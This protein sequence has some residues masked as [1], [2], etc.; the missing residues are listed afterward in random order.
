MRAAVGYRETD[1]GDVNKKIMVGNACGEN[2]S[3]HGSKAILLSHAVVAG[4]ITIASLS[5]HTSIGVNN[6]EAGP[7]NT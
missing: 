5:P 2:L 4:T 6:R 3:S 1:R 7:S